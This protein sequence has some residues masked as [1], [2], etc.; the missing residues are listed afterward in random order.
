MVRF[1]LYSQ[2][3]GKDEP[4]GSDYIRSVQLLK[5]WPEADLYKFGENPDVLV[6]Q[7][8]FSSEDYRFPQ[9]FEGIK[10][11][12]ICDPMWLEGFNVVDMAHAMDAITCPTQAIADFMSQFHNNVRVVP[13]RFDVDILPAPKKHAGK[14]KRVVW[15]GY[16][17]NAETLKPA[18]NIINELGLELLVISNDDPLLHRFGIKGKQDWYHYKKYDEKTIYDDL[19][20]A[21]FAILP[22][23]L[24]P[25]DPFK[26]NNKTVKSQL[27]GLPVA[28]TPEEV[29]EYMLASNRR[30]WYDDNYE[31]IKAEYDVRRSV[32]DMKYI[33]N[34]IRGKSG[35]E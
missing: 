21:D 13:D 17:H 32:D 33:I 28:K 15:F 20:T 2:F 26:S 8:V 23:G 9:H 30:K 7:K 11:L 34:E 24:R 4:T 18:L 5:Y 16:S 19:Q 35:N 31:I 29:N 3:H 10:I 12:D 1:F 25:E 6:F 22:D 14:A 27:A